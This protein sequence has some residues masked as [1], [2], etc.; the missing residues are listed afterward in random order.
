MQTRVQRRALRF[1]TYGELL[2]EVDRLAA[3]PY[4][5]AGKWSLTENCD[6]LRIFMECSMRGFGEARA[7]WILRL[8]APVGLRVTLLT[9][10]IPAGVRAPAPFQPA[11]ASADDPVRIEDFR[12][13]VR[14][15][16]AFP[17]PFHPSPLFGRLTP[18]QWHAIH[19]I[20][21]AHHLGF[22][23]PSA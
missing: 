13:T 6:H 23:V 7:P 9:K 8:M 19:L 10:K 3:G 22:L 17:G 11:A 5:R 12:K 4:R 1:S 16:E 20:H 14:L 15:L 18:R 2:A 21:A